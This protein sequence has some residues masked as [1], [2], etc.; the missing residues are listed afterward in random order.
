LKT[1][2]GWAVTHEDKKRIINNHFSAIMDS[3]P[4]RTSDFIWEHLHLP[5]VDL[6]SLDA[7]FTEQEVLAAIS[8][9]PS[10]KAPGP[11]GFM[12]LFFKTCWETIKMDIMAALNSFHIL[13]CED[14]NLLNSASV[15][16]I[17]KKDGAETVQDF[18]PISLIHAFAKI[19]SKILTIR[20]APR[21]DELIV[22]CQSAFIKGRS[23]HDNF[24]YVR[25]IARR[26]HQNKTPALLMKLDI[27]KAFD[28]VRWDFLL[29]LLQKRGFPTRWRD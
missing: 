12:G 2:R 8:Q 11:D 7:P 10:D 9:L 14:L 18:R 13:R 24:L 19:I 20:L 6:S 17:P 27:S 1:E 15:L 3:P 4:P 22:P 29:D 28:S 25:N 16:L 26:F 21:M 23:I 5:A